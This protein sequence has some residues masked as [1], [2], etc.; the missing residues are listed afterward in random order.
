MKYLKLFEGFDNYDIESIKDIF[1]DTIVDEYGIDEMTDRDYGEFGIFYKYNF[2]ISDNWWEEDHAQIEIW[3]ST[4]IDLELEY[5]FLELRDVGFK[6]FK[7]RMFL[8]GYDVLYS[9]RYYATL[10]KIKER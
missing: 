2:N 4:D 3:R 9:S 1:I 5:R 8:I 6:N 7:N 10:I